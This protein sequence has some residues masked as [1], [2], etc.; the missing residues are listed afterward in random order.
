MSEFTQAFMNE[1]DFPL[2]MLSNA[3]DLNDVVFVEFCTNF[4]VDLAAAKQIV[5]KRL[6]FANHKRHYLVLDMS[7]V[8]AVTAEAKKYL[9]AP[10]GG[11][12]N[13]LAAALIASNPV[14]ALIANIFIKTP[15]EFQA[16]FF[17]NKDD[18]FDWVCKQRQKAIRPTP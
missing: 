14:S 10:D 18:A 9:Q 17:S 7:N 16:K 5:A 12:Q 8:R 11:L 6:N 2:M 13:I 1:K 3:G 15:K 4:R